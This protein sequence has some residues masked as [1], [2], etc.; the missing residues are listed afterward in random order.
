M[1]WDNLTG[2]Y[3]DPMD[4]RPLCASHHKREDNRERPKV[5]QVPGVRMQLHL[6]AARSDRLRSYA[7]TNEMA[8]SACVRSALGLWLDA[9][10]GAEQ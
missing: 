9:N 7:S 5:P 3:G 2:N 6:D 8:L 10:E 4:Y 1:E